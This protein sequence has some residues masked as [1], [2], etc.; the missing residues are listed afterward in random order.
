M[1]SHDIVSHEQKEPTCTEAGWLAYVMCSYCGYNTYTEVSARGH[2]YGVGVITQQPTCE[3]EGVMTYTCYYCGDVHTSPIKATGHSYD[4]WKVAKEATC[5]EKGVEERVCLFDNTHK[6]TREF[7]PLGHNYGAWETTKE[8]T[9][10]VEGEQIRVCG[11]DTSHTETRSIPKTD[12][13]A[14]GADGVC[15]VCKKTIKN[16]LATPAVQAA[17]DTS[18]VWNNVANAEYYAVHILPQDVYVDVNTTMMNVEEYF[19]GNKYLYVYIQAVA[20][21]AGDY[22]NSVWSS[23]YTY[24][25]A[26]E[27]VVGTRG[28]GDAVN[29]L[30][31]GYT[32][33]ADGTTKIFDETLFNRLRLVN[34]TSVKKQQTVVTYAEGLDTYLNKITSNINN[35]T[36]V[37]A[38]VGYAKVAKATAGFEFE[39]GA[40][41]EASNYNETKAIFYDMDYYY[42]SNQ[43]EIYG[44]NDTEKLSSI[45]SVSFKAD[46]NRVANGTMSAGEFVKKYG[47]HIVTAGIYGA[48]FNAHYELLTNKATAEEMFGTNIKNTISA[49]ISGTVY[50]VEL[51][52]DTSNSTTAKTSDFVSTTNESLQSKFTA[53]AIGGAAQGVSGATSLDAFSSA[54]EV[55]AAGLNDDNCVLI[56]V[57]NES[58]VLVWDFLGSEYEETKNILNEYFY[59]QCDEQ[60][61]ALK[62]KISS[63]YSESVTFDE[64]RGI[65]TVNFAGL[66]T[67][68]SASLAGVSY[69][70]NANGIDFVDGV[71]TVYPMINGVP[72]EKVIFKGGYYQKDRSGQL[73]I[74]HF[75]NMSIVFN[76][77]WDTDIFVEFDSFAYE[78]KTGHVA[79]DFSAVQSENIT[80]NIINKA[81]IKGGNG[82]M[83]GASGQVAVLANNKNMTINGD[84]FIIVGG[85]GI[86][87]TVTGG[88]GGNGGMAMSV[89]TL[90][91][92]MVGALSI[93]GGNGGNGQIGYFGVNAGENGGNGGNGG[94]GGAAIQVNQLNVNAGEVII[95]GG[96]GGNGARGGDGQIGSTGKTVVNILTGGKDG[97]KNYGGKGGNGGNGGNGGAAG[98]AIIG[99]LNDVNNC[100]K[101]LNGVYGDGGNGGNGGKGGKGG[102]YYNSLGTVWR[103]GG[104]S[105]GN[106]GRGGDGRVYGVGGAAGLKGD[107]GSNNPVNGIGIG[108]NYGVIY[109]DFG[110]NAVDGISGNNGSTN[111]INR[112]SIS[113][114]C[115]T[116]YLISGTLS[117]Y[118]ANAY[119]QN[120]GGTLAVITSAEE[121]EIVSQLLNEV[122]IGGCWLGA[123][124]TSG[125]WKWVTGEEFVYSNWGEGEPNNNGGI[126][127]YLENYNGRWNDLSVGPTTVY[128][129]LVEVPN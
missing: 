108:I 57:P 30:T 109:H 50:G 99:I 92:D 66:Q 55:W 78:A 80:L 107:T 7:A 9:C 12:D 54:C 8:A 95:K 73:K 126:E 91:V 16:R 43:K 105:G 29:L 39:V 61:Y 88:A 65:L 21:P 79:L 87:A 10:A 60:Y 106:G 71:L 122:V 38:S 59:S 28:V 84:E 64:E 118:D 18:I 36:S 129:F 32:E 5:E 119:A 17:D 53:T 75:E 35:K 31:G 25:I 27:T 49:G 22:V 6:E 19:A 1:I 51:G 93:T 89:G 97:N 40:E 120:M 127:F 68:T 83:A 101:V 82:S 111:L 72:V 90:T 100:A 128:A 115:H 2:M 42:I 86:S 62:D 15:G 41:Y 45:L 63:L 74:N 124:S 121:N 4:V 77:H 116:Y 52:V 123:E 96:N 58:L 76:Q 98:L 26:G 125:E 24:E 85:H 94:S 56:D 69:E 117:W 34:D 13:H 104:G 102:N 110:N 23:V 14:V 114:D 112:G 20:D 47:T 67:Y 70:Q 44:Y 37:S 46:A 113:Y 81:Y 33:F 3:N 11:N 103:C 48:K